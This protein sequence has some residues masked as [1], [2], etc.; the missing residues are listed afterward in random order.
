MDFHRPVHDRIYRSN[1][2]SAKQA[3]LH[4]L[5][6]RSGRFAL[7]YPYLSDFFHRGQRV[8]PCGTD[9]PTAAGVSCAE[10]GSSHWGSESA[11]EF[12]P[13]EYREDHRFPVCR[14]S[15][16]HDPRD[17]DVC[18]RGADRGK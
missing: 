11:A 12:V 6:F 2:G 1:R 13:G 7:D 4:L 16:D 9:S 8:F 17:D 5:L 14:G 18:R 15:G 10:D 3:C